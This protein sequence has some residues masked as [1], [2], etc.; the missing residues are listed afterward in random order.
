MDH[1]TECEVHHLATMCS[2]IMPFLYPD[3]I[4]FEEG[5]YVDKNVLV[6]PDGSLRLYDGTLLF[7]FEGKS[8]MQKQYQ[9]TLHEVVPTR[10]IPQTL[11]KG[12][13]LKTAGTLYLCWTERSCSLFKVVTQHAY[14]RLICND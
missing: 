13:V 4:F 2:I 6:S 5:S 3:C 9:P 1:G 11:Y 8:P 14:L 10:Y 7:A 12:R